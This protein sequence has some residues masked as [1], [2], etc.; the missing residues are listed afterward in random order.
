M[1]NVDS[2]SCSPIFLFFKWKRG[3]KAFRHDFKQ[4]SPVFG[5][6][7]KETKFFPAFWVAVL[8]P[9]PGFFP[10]KKTKYL[11]QHVYSIIC[12]VK[13]QNIVMSIPFM[14][15]KLKKRPPS[16]NQ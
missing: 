10:W 11:T 3:H 4:M 7:V 15:N 6:I 16:E 14:E 2:N 1:I 8:M 5:K 9:I 13:W 12:K